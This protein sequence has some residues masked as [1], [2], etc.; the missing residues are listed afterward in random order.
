[1]SFDS[2]E[3]IFDVLVEIYV[4]L[5]SGTLVEGLYHVQQY[6]PHIYHVW[7][8]SEL[9]VAE[10]SASRYKLNILKLYSVLKHMDC[11]FYLIIYR[12]LH[13]LDSDFVNLTY[14][15]D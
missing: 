15:A 13:Y 3:A 10:I 11:N 6:I 12:E 2:F 1:M 7:D 5:R 9:R 8:N 4:D 14:E